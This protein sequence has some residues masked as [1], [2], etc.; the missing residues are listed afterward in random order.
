MANTNSIKKP[1][2]NDD[3]VS[4]LK[5]CSDTFGQLEAILNTIKQKSE[6]SSEIHKLADAGVYIAGDYENLADSWREEV[7]KVGVRGNELAGDIHATKVL[8]REKVMMN[9]SNKS[10]S[11]DN[12]DTLTARLTQAKSILGTLRLFGAD[13]DGEFKHNVEMIVDCFWAVDEFIEQAEMAALSL[14]E[15]ISKES[16]NV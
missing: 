6:T 16:S 7:E 3:V 10:I 12:Y 4:Y 2:S 1:S 15:N 13:P 14:W 8:V 5:C 11:I 9:S